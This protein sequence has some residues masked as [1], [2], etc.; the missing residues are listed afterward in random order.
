VRAKGY[1]ATNVDEIC[2][3]AGVTKGGFF[4][5]FKSKEDWAVAAAGYW[6]DVTG[7]LF[8]SA[9]YHEPEDPLER[10]LAY[11]TLRRDLIRGEPSEFT[12]LL[13]TMTQEAYDTSPAI[14]SAC[15]QGICGHA[16]TLVPDI[17]AAMDKYGCD[18]TWTAQ[19]LALHTQAVI[20]GAFILAKA[21]GEPDRATESIGHLHRYIELLFRKP[22]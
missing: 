8:E 3:E 4:H 17:Q 12:C 11:V 18:G 22:G 14:Q 10:V 19:S 16:D 5:H 13:G 9:A 20:Q 15:W 2:A 1:S 7:A 6:S 21:S